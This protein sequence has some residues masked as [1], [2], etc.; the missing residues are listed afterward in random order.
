MTGQ[1]R[2][3]RLQADEKPADSA[4]PAKVE[5]PAG[6]VADA[7][8]KT[9]TL[10]GHALAVTS[11]AFSPDGKRLISAS[12]G[13]QKTTKSGEVKMWDAVTGQELL[14]LKGH[15]ESVW[16]VAFSPDG[17]QVASGS[18][19]VIQLQRNKPGEV[20]L[21]DADTGE[22][23]LLLKGHIHRVR[24]VAFSPDGKWLASASD[25]RTLKVWDMATG[26]ELLNLTA[27]TG[28]VSSVAFSPDG[29]RLA[30]ASGI[31]GYGGKWLGKDYFYGDESCELK[32][33]DVSTG[34]VSLRLKGLAGPVTSMAFSADGNRLASASL[35][36]LNYLLETYSMA[37]KTLPAVRDDRTVRVWDTATGL[38]SLTLEGR[39]GSVSSIAMSP[40]GKWLGTAQ[41]RAVKVWN[42]N[43]GQESLT[44]NEHTDQ[45]TCVAFSPDGK[46]LAT[47]SRD[48]TVKVWNVTPRQ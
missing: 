38:A 37:G 21:W 17:K 3:N 6:Q 31:Y 19:D 22:E 5:P 36:S 34:R 27:F 45:V 8:P 23:I 29:K 40:N 1:G 20:R 9:L 10:E 46:R 11:V 7:G 41:D 25:D 35:N 2:D 26:Q 30:S 43:T 4:A 28:P 32:L 42:A 33:W 39:L 48:K 15:T 14:T 13:F 12:G 44:L 18:G 47:A 16:S 24:C